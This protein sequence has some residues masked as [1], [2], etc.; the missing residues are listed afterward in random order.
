MSS[1][2]KILV[3]LG[4]LFA[5][6]A[7]FVAYFVLGVGEPAPPAAPTGTPEPPPPD[8]PAA[9]PPAP[10]PRPDE[11]PPPANG[12]SSCPVAMPD[13]ERHVT[14]QRKPD[15]DR[16]GEFLR[17]V[18]LET[19]GEV[20]AGRLPKRKDPKGYVNVYW[21]PVEGKH[22]P[23]VRIQDAEGE[24]LLTFRSKTIA[25]MLRV[26]NVTYAGVLVNGESDYGWTEGT[27]G[28]VFVTI[29]GHQA[30]RLPG[31]LAESLGRYLGRIEAGKDGLWFVPAADAAEA[32]FTKQD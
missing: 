2:S 7:G 24:Y 20:K 16:P 30:I 32:P 23:F 27:D 8:P 18:R 31:R 3:V 14:F 22:G 26:K 5:V 19:P 13:G 28:K 1:D 21:Y 11:T 15:P 12:W 29:A 10:A 17:R 6:V 25:R 9:K 4:I